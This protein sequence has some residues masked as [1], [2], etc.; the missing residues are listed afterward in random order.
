LLNV[1]Q[2][3]FILGRIHSENSCV[4]SWNNIALNSEG[5]LF[6]CERRS[7]LSGSQHLQSVDVPFVYWNYQ[8]WIGADVFPC[9][10]FEA[11]YFLDSSFTLGTFDIASSFIILIIS[12]A[13]HFINFILISS[14]IYYS[15]LMIYDPAYI[16]IDSAKKG[17]S[18]G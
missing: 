5:D 17:F 18:F 4:I 13:G 11:C 6:G 1:I 2:I 14:L 16:S 3:P 7:S 12:L 10:G 8:D 15:S 9:H